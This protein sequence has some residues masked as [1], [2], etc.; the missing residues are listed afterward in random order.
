M[1]EFTTT[2]PVGISV[3]RSKHHRREQDDFNTKV[4]S[5]M[6]EKVGEDRSFFF[7]FG[8]ET[9]AVLALMPN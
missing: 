2:C 1:G 6:G 7:F 4:R 3:P 8:S 9:G 5:G